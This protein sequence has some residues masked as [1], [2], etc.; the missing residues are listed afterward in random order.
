VEIQI[1]YAIGVAE[2]VSLN[3]D[4][5]DTGN[6]GLAEQFAARFDYRPAAIIERLDLLKPI[7][8]GTTNYGHF[9]KPHLTWE[10]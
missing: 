10:Q 7:Y 1:A 8:R 9:G 3:V 6:A 5:C 4:T 2:P